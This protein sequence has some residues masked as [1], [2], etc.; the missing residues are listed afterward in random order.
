[1]SDRSYRTYVGT[2][3][4]YDENEDRK[5]VVHDK[6]NRSEFYD[7]YKNKIRRDYTQNKIIGWFER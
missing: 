4:D 2:H 6:T 5:K 3:T 7:K 1:M